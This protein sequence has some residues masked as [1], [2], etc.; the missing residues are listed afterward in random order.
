MAQN[1]AEIGARK[2]IARVVLPL[3]FLIFLSSLDRV[4][5]SFAQ[6]RMNDALGLSPSAY[7]LGV[8]LFFIG[9]LLFQAPSLWLLD[10]IGARWW[11]ALTVFTWGLIASAMAFVETR[12]H[13]YILR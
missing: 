3:V 1:E 8:S 10:K 5:V 13:F 12:A 7:G 9:Y 2:I 4:N 6:L 11:I